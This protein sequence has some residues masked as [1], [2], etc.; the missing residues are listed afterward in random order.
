MH[1]HVEMWALV[2][3]RPLHHFVKITTRVDDI[4]SRNC[5]LCFV[6]PL[7]DKNTE[8]I[9]YRELLTYLARDGVHAP[10]V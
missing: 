10:N 9:V 4:H 8:M 3:L 7:P 2:F 1:I 5:N 6:V